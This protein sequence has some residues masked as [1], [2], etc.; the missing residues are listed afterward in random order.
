MILRLGD[1]KEFIRGGASPLLR[2]AVYVM[3]QIESMIA[4]G[5]YQMHSSIMMAGY[6]MYI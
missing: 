6:P 3:D 1:S 4:G 5:R 2:V